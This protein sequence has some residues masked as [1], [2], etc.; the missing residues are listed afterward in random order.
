MALFGFSKDRKPGGNS[1]LVLA[2]LED[3]QR[4]RSPLFLRDGRKVD[5]QATLQSLDEEAG[6]MALH[7]STPFSG[8]RGSKVDLLLYHEGLRIGASARVAELRSG[9]VVLDLPEDLELRERRKQPRVRLNPKEGATLT[10][11]TSLFEGVGINGTLENLSEGGCRVRVD[12]ALN[13]K[14]ERRLPLGAALVPVGHAFMLLKLNKVP[15]CPAVIE[16]AG[17]VVYVD[18]S[19]GLCLGIAFEKLRGDAVTAIKGLVSSR[20]GTPP[21]TLPPKARRK[22]V[23]DEEPLERPTRREEPPPAP[24]EKPAPPPVPKPAPAPDLATEPPA[25]PP[26]PNPEVESA[27]APRNPALLRLKKRS[28]TLLVLGN[29]AGVDLLK[30]HLEE[31]GYGRV[32]LALDWA[33][34][35]TRLQEAPIELLLVDLERPILEIMEMLGK[36]QEAELDLPPVVLAADEVSRGIVVAATRVGVAHLLVRPYLLDESFS[37]MIETQLGLG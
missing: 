31:E 19:S 17:T 11:L 33:E 5:L 4:V 18:D 13:V 14:D 24:R 10:G 15:R 9:L 28:R 3:A 1:E 30:T 27:S 6:T 29:G 12:K 32:L 23:M 16:T 2:Y 34:T 20:A 25:P 7:L 35:I 36:L 26:A 21:S 8:E 37:R 22:T